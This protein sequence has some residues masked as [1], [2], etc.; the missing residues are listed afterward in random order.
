M[1]TANAGNTPLSTRAV[2]VL[3]PAERSRLYA[4]SGAATSMIT[5]FVIERSRLAISGLVPAVGLASRLAST[6]SAFRAG[7]R[8]PVLVWPRQALLPRAR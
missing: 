8:I 2:T 7:L 1:A 6:T 3:I 4:M 5:I